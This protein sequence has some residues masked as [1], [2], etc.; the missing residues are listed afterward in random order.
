MASEEK[1]VTRTEEEPLVPEEHMEEPVFSPQ[2]DIVEKKDSVVILADMPGVSKEN[3]DV[4]LEKGVLTIE[5]RV[6]EQEPDLELQRQEYQVGTFHRRFAV[7]EGLDVEN[8]EATMEDGVLRL[9]ISKSE[10]YQPRRIQI[11]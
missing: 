3:V 8:V 9:S 1:Q 4:V 11:Q 5:G 10:H 6:E 2:V 7:G